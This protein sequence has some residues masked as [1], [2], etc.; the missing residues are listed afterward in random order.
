MEFSKALTV[1]VAALPLLGAEYRVK[2]GTL[3]I[4]E[5]GVSYQETGKK[6]PRHWSWSY[7]DIQQLDLAPARVRV[8]T[9]EDNRWKL[10][11]DRGYA[12]EPLAGQDFSGSY[13]LL[14]D[15]LD[16]RFV[17]E[18][19]D[20]AV[21]PLWSVPVKLLG[22]IAGS[23]GTLSIGQDRI[24][25]STARKNA[26]RTWRYGDIDNIATSGPFELTLTTFER[27]IEHYGNR[28]D[29]NFQLKEPLDERRYNELWRKL[30]HE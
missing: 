15:R 21:R 22:T 24:V 13:P 8:L 2:H 11:A 19:A 30:H 20:A 25:Y 14:K 18:L 4:D 23:Q 6:H 7:Q 9:Y 1:L 10:G 12:F 27:A 16:R 29:F 5:R 3:T 17:A 28:K 26:S